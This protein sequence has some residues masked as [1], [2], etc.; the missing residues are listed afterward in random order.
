MTKKTKPELAAILAELEATIE[1]L[2]NSEGNL[3]DSLG[4]FQ[5]GIELTRTAQALLTEAEQTV[6]TLTADGDILTDLPET[7]EP[8]E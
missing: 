2:E 6:R 1:K 7:N 4:A 8:G 5:H 3:E